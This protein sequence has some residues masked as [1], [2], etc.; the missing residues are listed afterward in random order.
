MPH[1]SGSDPQSRTR[2]CPIVFCCGPDGVDFH[3]RDVGLEK[4]SVASS[5]VELGFPFGANN[6]SPIVAALDYMLRHSRYKEAW[7]ASHLVSPDAITHIRIPWL[8]ASLAPMPGL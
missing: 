8:P 3:C 2:R 5:T 6:D 1:P 4:L 7:L